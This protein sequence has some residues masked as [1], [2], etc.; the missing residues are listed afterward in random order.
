MLGNPTKPNSESRANSS[1]DRKGMCKCLTVEE[2]IKQN[3]LDRTVSVVNSPMEIRF[4]YTSN[5]CVS[6]FNPTNLLQGY[7]S[8]LNSLNVLL[9]KTQFFRLWLVYCPGK[10]GTCS[11]FSK[12][13]ALAI[14]SV[15]SCAPTAQTW[16]SRFTRSY[17]TSIIYTIYVYLPMEE[18]MRLLS[19]ISCQSRCT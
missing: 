1:R 16:E 19:F 15:W 10:I 5:Y 2:K 12:D 3:Y 13:C 14:F 9:L 6:S 4:R 17:I 7:I 11:L 8:C 18:C